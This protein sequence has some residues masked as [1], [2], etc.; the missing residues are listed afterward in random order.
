MRKE[1]LILALIIVLGVALRVAV[2]P[3]YGGTYKPV[4]VYFVDAQAPRLILS[5]QNPYAYTY[6]VHNYTTS[7]FAY[8]PMVPIYYLPF[9]LLGDVRYGNIFA[10]VMIMLA[11]FWIAKSFKL[12]TAVY[13]PL[14]F[15]VLP[16]S[17]WLTSITATNFMVGTAFLTLSLAALLRKKYT[18]VAVLLGLGVATNQLVSLTLPLFAYYYWKE[19]KLSRFL[20]SLAVAAAI[21][22]PFIF[23]APSKFYYDIVEYQFTR[24]LQADGPFSLYSILNTFL[25]I[26]LNTLTRIVIFS[27][28]YLL[29]AFAFRKKSNLLILAAGIVL[30]SAAFV[31]PVN[32]LWNYFLPTFA[33]CCILAPLA[34][35]EV[36]RRMLGVK[37]WPHIF[38]YEEADTENQVKAADTKSF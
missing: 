3:V 28:S 33:L 16:W 38:K 24:S 22:L 11:L 32:G 36:D 2:I 13:A 20:P 30:F 19:G 9:Y 15:A 1:L 5:L 18:I 23:A 37:W 10:D 21:I 25:R 8:L 4:D 12:K 35:D 14:A 27:V 29:A 17:I 34:G 26:D 7:V 6:A 31:L